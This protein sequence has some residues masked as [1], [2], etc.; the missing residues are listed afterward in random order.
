MVVACLEGGRYRVDRP[1][2]VGDVGVL[3]EELI[4]KSNGEGALLGFD[5][6]IGLPAGYARRAG[7]S[8][9]RSTLR[10]L[11]T[12]R[13]SHFFEPAVLA[14][15]IS[16]ERPFYPFRPGGTRQAHLVT[17]LGVTSMDELLRRCERAY[18][19]RS[20]ACCLFWTLGGNQVGRAAISGW[21]DVLAPSLARLG[22]EVGLWPFD[23]DL[24]QLLQTRACVAV[25]TYPADAC[26][27]LGFPPPGRGW[28]KRRQTDRYRL[29]QWL[30]QSAMSGNVALTESLRR[31][32][33]LG[34]GTARDGEDRFD[35]FVGNLAMLGVVQGHRDEG[36]PRDAIIRSVEGW[37]LGQE[38]RPTL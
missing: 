17:G 26:V 29:S 20:G 16:L 12:G 13:W 5:F 31:D 9:F 38:S 33:D 37:I 14:T 22:R 36:T 24:P 19:T 1:L 28:S 30:V 18:G 3:V 8:D 6:P 32:I 4:D 11:G 7:I 15:D 35:A 34:F 23:G 25:E 21:R 2:P 27:Q 10:L